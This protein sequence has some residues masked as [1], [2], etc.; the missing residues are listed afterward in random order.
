MFGPPTQ[1][2]TAKTNGNSRKPTATGTTTS[3]ANVKARQS[4]PNMKESM[5]V[6]PIATVAASEYANTIRSASSTSSRVGLT[7]PAAPL[8]SLSFA[9]RKALSLVPSTTATATAEQNHAT[10]DSQK[11]KPTSTAKVTTKLTSAPTTASR[12]GKPSVTARSGP[13]RAVSSTALSSGGGATRLKV[14]TRAVSTIPAPAVASHKQPPESSVPSEEKFEA[15]SLSNILNADSARDLDS[16]D[17]GGMGAQFPVAAEQ[18]A[19]N[20]LT[21]QCAPFD[22]SIA[23]DNDIYKKRNSIYAGPVRVL[24]KNVAPIAPPRLQISDVFTSYRESR[25]SL[26]PSFSQQQPSR[27]EDTLSLSGAPK[28]VPQKSNTQQQQQAQILQNSSLLSATTATSLTESQLGTPGRVLSQPQ[29]VPKTGASVV[30]PNTSAILGV[31]RPMNAVQII[32]TPRRV[33]EQ[34]IA[35]TVGKTVLM[36]SVFAPPTTRAGRGGNLMQRFE[37][38]DAREISEA[39]GTKASGMGGDDRDTAGK[40]VA[41]ESNQQ[42][43]D[44]HAH[45]VPIRQE[46]QQQNELSLNEAE[47]QQQQQVKNFVEPSVNNTKLKSN[48]TEEFHDAIIAAASVIAPPRMLLPNPFEVLGMVQPPS[49]RTEVSSPP[50]IPPVSVLEIDNEL[51]IVD[52]HSAQDLEDGKHAINDMLST[53]C[54]GQNDAQMWKPVSPRKQVL[55][56]NGTLQDASDEYRG[57]VRADLIFDKNAVEEDVPTTEREELAAVVAEIHNDHGNNSHQDLVVAIVPE[58]FDLNDSGLEQSVGAQGEGNDYREICV[59]HVEILSDEDL[60]STVLDSEVHEDQHHHQTAVDYLT[61]LEKQFRS[62]A[63]H[64]L[65]SIST[66]HGVDAEGTAA[67]AI[68]AEAGDGSD[69]KPLVAVDDEALLGTAKTQTAT[70]EQID[71]EINELDEEERKILKE[72]LKLEGK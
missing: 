22:I 38:A 28:R 23:Q 58:N 62:V 71:L 67:A 24:K 18:P 16:R 7:R 64:L 43:S 59:N 35:R 37:A 6:K 72:I 33:I 13:T 26:A 56:E 12:A 40:N 32:Q 44:Y 63:G 45:D 46:L 9:Q 11:L 10:L 48:S 30:L 41:G 47:N 17:F 50:Q 42:I 5:S 69:K 29:R 68:A 52:E 21:R 8:A 53:L 4:A 49:L 19:R 54:D 61:N 60:Q 65:A 51:T 36:D 31:S 25:F 15:L 27:F 14:Q 20:G 2:N 3:N 66:K 39:V 34:N 1:R 55:T 70:H 57:G